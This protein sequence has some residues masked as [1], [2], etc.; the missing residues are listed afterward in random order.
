MVHAGA[1]AAWLLAKMMSCGGI[2]FDNDYSRRNFV[3]MGA[4]SGVAA[5][6]HAPIGGILFSL[7]E[8]SSFWDPKLMLDSFITASIAAFTGQLWERLYAELTGQER[9][10]LLNWRTAEAELES[11][12]SAP[13]EVW[14]LFIFIMMGCVCGLL[15]A[16]FNSVNRRLT[17]FRKRIFSGRIRLR[18]LE[19]L[20]SICLVI[21]LFF[22]LP[23]A[24]PQCRGSFETTAPGF[25]LKTHPACDGEQS[26]S[27]ARGFSEL[28]SL[29]GQTQEHAL[30]LLFS[31]ATHGLFSSGT[32]LVFSLLFA[33]AC[34]MRHHFLEPRG[35]PVIFS[36][37][38]AAYSL[39]A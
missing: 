2:N 32:L 11:L 36:R 5:A 17:I 15:G 12:A 18:V 1:I 38:R 23:V 7:E 14:E 39:Y 34:A 20:L 19:A 22:W 35:K 29:L 25:H 8:V 3:S 30:T 13:Y 27:S 28:A 21:S 26:D 31:H 6:F 4:A 16:A 10:K 24:M 33:S 37:V 9:H